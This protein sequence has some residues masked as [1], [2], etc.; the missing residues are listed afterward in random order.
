MLEGERELAARL[1]RELDG[2]SN[3]RVRSRV[4]KRGENAAV[5]CRRM[6]WP[7]RSDSAHARALREEFVQPWDLAPLYLRRPDAEI[8][9]I[10]RDGLVRGRTPGDPAGDVPGTGEVA[11]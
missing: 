4:R 1:G 3:A 5:L 8:N 6:P 2:Q 11:G 7:V 9:W 10:T